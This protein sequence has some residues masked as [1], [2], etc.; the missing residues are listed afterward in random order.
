MS[1]PDFEIIE[2][3]SPCSYIRQYP[4]SAK[5][6]D[7][8]LHLAVK[9][10]RPL[11][12][13][14]PGLETVTIIAAHGNGFPKEMYE[15]LFTA[16]HASPKP[17]AIHSIWIA[18]Q[19]NMSASHA[20]NAPD[21]GDDPHWLDH[22]LDLLLMLN[23][24][25]HLM[26]P[27]FIGLAHSMGCAQLLH[28][29]NIHTRLFQSLVLIEPVLLPAHPPGPNAALFSSL[30]RETWGSR[31]EAE[32]QIAR[33]PFFAAMH[34]DA[35]SLFLAHGLRDTPTGVTLSTPKAQEAWSYVRSNLLAISEDSQRERMLNPDFVPGSEP[36]RLVT[37]RGELLAVCESLPRIRPRV[38]FI[39]G[40]ESHINAPAVRASHAS[41]TGSGRGGNG[42]VAEG[43]VKQ[44]VLEDC[45]HLCVFEKP[46]AI[47]HLVRPWMGGE[48][49]RWRDEKTFW[50]T[51]DTKKSINGR[52]G[53]S[54]E[55]IAAVKADTGTERR[56]GEGKARL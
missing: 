5:S 31:G 20:L 14:E 23:T 45:G 2:H 51:V 47:A 29:S 43:G 55:W 13:P 44:A 39:Y 50:D 25:R 18:D 56:E 4:H 28:L 10:Y 1:S 12:A 30:R 53:V 37:A 7:A 27:P 8:V 16:L 11:K 26:A 48:V 46:G 52:S 34:P 33:S 41:D 35:L 49:E 40:E 3:T 24:F 19:A 6:D 36:A 54:K 32:R 21:L 17:Y 22:S 38:Y 15:P 42:G 9:E